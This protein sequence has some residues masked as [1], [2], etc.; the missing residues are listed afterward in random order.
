[1]TVLVGCATVAGSTR[2]I[3]QRIGERPGR[4]AALPARPLGS[5]GAVSGCEDFVLGSAVHGPASV[6]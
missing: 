4:P 2:E 3:V 6:A 5:V 1:M